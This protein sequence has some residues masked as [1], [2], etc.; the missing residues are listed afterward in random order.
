[1]N[2]PRL[3]PLAALK[4]FEAAARHRSFSAAGRELGVTHAAVSQQVRRLEDLLRT[5]LAVREG[6][7]LG[8]TA[9]GERLAARLAEGFAILRDAVRELADSQAA[10]PVHVSMTPSFAANWLLPRLGEFRARH[11]EVDL[12]L[13]PSVDLVDLSRDGYDLA[14]RFGTGGWPGVESE[15]LVPSRFVVVA[16][17]R[18]VADAPVRTPEDLLGL[19]WL[20]ELGTDELTAWLAAN[21][22]V[23]PARR[24]V[25]HLPGYMLLPALRDAQGVACTARVFVEDDLRDGRLVVL[26]EDDTRFVAGDDRPLGYHLAYRAGRLRAP[27]AVFVDWLRGAA[28]ADAGPR[29]DVAQE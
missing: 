24:N 13:N 6:R 2:E 7:G 29:R 11:P 15:P 27:L 17:A 4:A 14:I 12:M 10:R 20:Q 23:A 3:P 1:M 9:D 25:T 21:G 8:L 28:R 18:L 19:P 5:P 16:A 26:F 22:V